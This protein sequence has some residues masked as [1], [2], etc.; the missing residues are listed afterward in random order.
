MKLMEWSE[1]ARAQ[2]PASPGRRNV[3]LAAALTLGSSLLFSAACGSSDEKRR[4]MDEGGAGGQ[5]GASSRAGSPI[6]N[7]GGDSTNAGAAGSASNA[8]TSGA[9]VAESGGSPGEMPGA[10][11]AAAVGGVGDAGS[12]TGEH[13]VGRGALFVA[14]GG[15]HTCVVLENGALRCWGSASLGQLGYGNIVT[16]GDDE[17]PADAGDVNVGGRVTQVSASGT[18]TCALLSTG[19]VRCWG[20]GYWGN[21]G[22]GNTSTIGDDESVAS[23]GDVNIGGQVTQVGASSAHTCA[24]LSTGS[25]RCWGANQDGRLG[26]GNLSTAT[27][28]GD[29]E[30]PASAGNVPIGGLVT[31]ISVGTKHACALLSTGAVRCWGNNDDGQLGYASTTSIGDNE[32][33]ASAGDVNVGDDVTQVSAG[34]SHTCALLSSGTVRCWGRGLE[35]E[36]GYGN[37]NSIGDNEAPATA[38]DVDVGGE[39]AQIAA[40]AEFTCALLVSGAV[41]CWGRNTYGGLGYLNT[42][43]IGDDEAPASVGD[44]DLGEEATQIAAGA[45]PYACAVLASSAVRCWGFADGGQLG[46][47]NL[48]RIGDDETPASA[49]DVPY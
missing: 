28:I 36:L 14:T 40:G 26:Y 17:R 5:G 45:G 49:G 32:T 15:A 19:S 25:V 6:E 39:V 4:V 3:A 2:P 9:P 23:A 44:L 48:E 18:S 7:P 33:P 46:Y 42:E 38:G 24:L 16:I 22:Y 27:N 30:L 10:A 11:G 8:G 21:L 34:N 43:A 31:Q 13:V 35:G 37:T 41:R 29:D 20:N 12:G 47:G 1:A